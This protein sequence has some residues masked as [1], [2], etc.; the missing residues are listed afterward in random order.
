[1]IHLRDTDFT[2]QVNCYTFRSATF[3]QSRIINFMLVIQRT[4]F[5]IIYLLITDFFAILT[6]KLGR[7]LRNFAESLETFVVEFIFGSCIMSWNRQHE[8]KSEIKTRLK[9]FL[10]ILVIRSYFFWSD[11]N[12]IHSPFYQSILLILEWLR[13]FNL[14][15]F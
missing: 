10:D 12:F 15:V 5:M 8:K 9:P 14:I 13:E 6:W 11:V 2:S 1:M 3:Y 4:V 7:N